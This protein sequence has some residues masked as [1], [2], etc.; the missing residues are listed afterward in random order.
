MHCLTK[1]NA[2]TKTK[3]YVWIRFFLGWTRTHTGDTAP[4][5]PHL[6]HSFGTWLLSKLLALFFSLGNLTFQSHVHDPSKPTKVQ[7]FYLICKAVVLFWLRPNWLK[8]QVNSLKCSIEIWKF[9]RAFHPWWHCQFFVH[10]RRLGECPIT[11][12]V[13]GR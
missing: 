1:Q 3:A 8:G 7:Y 11:T 12:L 6:T 13:Q 2:K 5:Y 9:L 10:E 4:P